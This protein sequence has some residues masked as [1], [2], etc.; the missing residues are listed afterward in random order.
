MKNKIIQDALINNYAIPQFNINNLEWIK[1]ILSECNNLNSPV[2]LGVSTSAAKY[3]CGYKNVVNM[4]N[5]IKEYLNIK[6]PTI[7]H[8]DHATTYEECVSAI[9]AGFD[10]V[11]I[12]ASSSLL[13]DNIKLTNQVC[14]YAH[15]HNVLVE[16]EIGHI[17]ED[18]NINCT[19]VEDANNF[20][21]QTDIDLLAAAVG[22]AHGCYNVKPHIQ[23]DLITKIKESTN[24]PLVLHGGS[25]LSDECLKKCIKNGINKINFNTELQLAWSKELKS[26][27]KENKDVAEEIEEKVRQYYG[28]SLNKKEEK[29]V[30]KE[31]KEKKES[32]KE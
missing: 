20:Y 23:Y 1:T 9:D 4:V 27:L 12:D 31:T 17:S 24:L 26:Y 11:M 29:E 6:I 19:S 3:M 15:K 28:I 13:T 7:I 10:S 14:N 25:G 30:K 21:K 5:N 16:A 8:L 18:I 2:I 32:V 22:T